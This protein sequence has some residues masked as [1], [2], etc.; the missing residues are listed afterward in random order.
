MPEP[1]TPT[2][3][4]EVAE[5]AAEDK[6]VFDDRQKARINELIKGA[7]GRAGKEARERAAELETELATLRTKLPHEEPNLALEL[8]TTKAELKALKD[9]QR[10]NTVKEAL[11]RAASDTYIDQE[12]GIRLMR[13]RVS[14]DDNGR[15]TVLAADGTPALNGSTLEPA[16]L[17]DLAQTIANEK[18]Y[19][20][21][22][23]VRPGSG[24]ALNQNQQSSLPKLETLF[25]PRSD[26][27][28]ANKLAMR[29][30]ALYHQ[31]KAQARER[32]LLV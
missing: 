23:A 6:V 29:N 1:E 9:A 21:R 15:I 16:T 13:D 10:E 7:M 18:K 27:G 11:R 30:P 26:G 28:A 3:N 12:L 19:L 4:V 14:V 5:P 8:D 20:A 32:G 31:L 22:S 2:A 25:G 17:A 24:S